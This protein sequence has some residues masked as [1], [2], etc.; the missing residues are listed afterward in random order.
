MAIA[1]P[2]SSEKD[3]WSAHADWL[4]TTAAL[5]VQAAAAAAKALKFSNFLFLGSKSGIF[6]SYA[7]QPNGCSVVSRW[8]PLCFVCGA[9]CLSAGLISS[10]L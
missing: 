10:W 6:F 3:N 2:V 1:L 7:V 8:R 5:K 9:A 4:H